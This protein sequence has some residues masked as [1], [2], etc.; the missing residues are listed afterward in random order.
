METE[1]VLGFIALVVVSNFV[2]HVVRRKPFLSGYR[3]RST[4]NSVR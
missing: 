2:D 4:G 1:L 3:W